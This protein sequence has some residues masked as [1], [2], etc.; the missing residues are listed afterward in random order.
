MVHGRDRELRAISA[1]ATELDPTTLV[2][3]GLSGV[4]KTVTVLAALR[5]IGAHPTTVRV[6][7]SCSSRPY[8]QGRS[9]RE[10]LDLAR[11][12]APAESEPGYE[13]DADGLLDT[14][15]AGFELAGTGPRVLFVDDVDVLSTGRAAWLQ[16]L[17]DLA[18]GRGWR[19]VAAVRHVPEGPRPDD[20][21]V[22]DID[23]LDEASLRLVLNGEL[24]LPLAVDVA[25]RLH[26]WSSG[27][28]RIAL[29][30]ADE[31]S[32]AQLRGDAG[33]IGPET[34]GPVARRA[35]RYL[36]DGLA[37]PAPAGRELGEVR[38]N[39]PTSYH[40][41]LALLRGEPVAGVPQSDGYSVFPGSATLAEMIL[42]GLHLD[43]LSGMPQIDGEPRAAARAAGVTLL[44]GTTWADDSA[45]QWVPA[46]V[47]PEW[48][49]HLWW[50]EGAIVNHR[51]RAAGSRVA[52][53]L[54]KLE[55]TGRI[56]DPDRLRTDLGVIG[57][58]SDL[59]WVGLCIQVRGRLLLG[60]GPGA[61]QL[62]EDQQ[63]T[64][65]GR[66][67]A[68][69]VARDLAA[70]RVAM[71]D[72]R[73][74]D[75]RARLAHA[76]ELRPSVADWLPV[77]GL[78]AAAAAMLDGREPTSQR[79]PR[80]G[81]WS[82]RALGEF[83]V[84]LGAAH[85]A[86]GHAARA[87]EL[88]TIGLERCAWPYR[89][90]VQARADLVEAAMHSGAI[91]D[92]VPRSVRRLVEPPTEPQER[93]DA[94]PR[95]AHARMHAILAGQAVGPAGVEEW[96]PAAPPSVSLWQHLRFLVAY[97]GY[98]KAR[99]NHES[100]ESA[101]QEARALAA[102]AGMPGWRVAIDTY[103]AGLSTAD[104]PDWSGLNTGEREL[105]RLALGGATNVQIAEMTYLSLRTVA[106]RFRQIYAHLQVRDRRELNELGTVN[107]PGWLA[108]QR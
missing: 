12:T 11:W 100:T 71:F 58:T 78:R 15:G 72:G 19:V 37:V 63:G 34:V 40:P 26:W 77:Q 83:A 51:Q 20:M 101:V 56:S 91:R 50:R 14:V 70:A 84:D 38:A 92:E 79:P 16:Y 32:P 62:L 9:G 89:G 61:R 31:L 64:V 106:N 35:Y 68:E 46:S 10:R 53:A 33:W 36:L 23:P 108:D 65:S 52:A 102:L 25:E 97:A 103:A 75:A 30:L 18:Y 44:T 82:T 5:Q 81:T 28:P 43:S 45:R 1:F 80:P 48:T 3:S 29:E 22:L 39:R 95:A 69:I 105:V 54:I 59:H 86:V 94:E 87:A 8:A 7:R 17:G 4:G 60:D 67:V 76:T 6:V 66:S 42:D 99:G 98:S 57:S 27:S 47:G 85:L 24:G 96:L 90:R 49:D 21:D 13:I 74:E 73:A 41:L 88:L 107:P 104:R 2:V 93:A 55:R